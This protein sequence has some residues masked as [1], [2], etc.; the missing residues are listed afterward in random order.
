VS[1]ITAG[2]PI[3]AKFKSQW[4]LTVGGDALVEAMIAD[5]GKPAFEARGGDIEFPR[6]EIRFV[7]G[8]LAQWARPRRPRLSLRDLPGKAWLVPEPLGVVLI[9]AP[10]NSPV[11]LLLSPMANALAAGN[12]VVAK[13][14]ELAPATS[15]VLARLLREHMDPEAVA[16]V[17]GG[18]ETAEALLAQRF[19]HILF[20]GST[21]VGRVVARAAAE[22]LVPVTLELGGKSPAIVTADADLDITARRL[23][24]GK[25]ANA[26]QACI[27][28]DYAL[29]HREVRDRFVERLVASMTRFY[30]PDPLAG[31]DLA[32]IINGA[33]TRRLAR[34]LEDHG[35]RVALGGQVDLERRLVAPT[36]VVDPDPDSP[37]MQEE[38]FGPVLPVLTV[39]DLDEAIRFVNERPKPLALYLFTTADDTAQRVIEE[40]SSG[41]ICVNHTLFH[42]ST[43]ALP[44]GGVGDSGHGSYRG[45]AG[46]ETFSHL[47]PVLRKPLRPD[48]LMVYPPYTKLKQLLV[49]GWLRQR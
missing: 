43:T 22:K 24:W 36:I 46:F 39:D 28:P 19:D 30:G 35:G 11:Q 15:H 4:A 17:D 18:V 31:S 40:T 23:A 25:C 21:A 33:H 16:V 9:I 38:I 14:S 6:R 47:K 49:T 12:A 20:T 10:W 32:G 2:V 8:R 13:P 42:I 37:L 41:G 45:A 34:L 44:F 3:G 27:A 5:Q 26:G 1:E 48:L 29:V 7:R